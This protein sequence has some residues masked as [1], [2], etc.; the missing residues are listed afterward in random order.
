MGESK[1]V[2]TNTS[3]KKNEVKSNILLVN[4]IGNE[5]KKLR[6]EA[7]TRV[8]GKYSMLPDTLT[9]S[10]GGLFNISGN[11]LNKTVGLEFRDKSL[12][13][14]THDN[15]TLYSNTIREKYTTINGGVGNTKAE[16]LDIPK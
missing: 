16:L 7:L 5:N 15:T 3:N 8:W 2:N 14:Y 11:L 1:K 10:L 4:G 12:Y 6:D 13:D 9:N